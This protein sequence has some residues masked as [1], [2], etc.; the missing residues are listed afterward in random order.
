MATTA[1][2]EA[3]TSRLGSPRARRVVS[4]S[5]AAGTAVITVSTL[6]LGFVAVRNVTNQAEGDILVLMAAIVG[7]AS[8]G[9]VGAILAAR[10]PTSPLGFLFQIGAFSMALAVGGSVYGARA[11]ADLPGLR[12]VPY[13]GW[14][15]QI[16]FTPAFG[17]TFSVF[18]LFPD[19]LPPSRRWRPVSWL[20]W[21]GAVLAAVGTTFGLR[22]F[23]FDPGV[24][25]NPF[26][27][28]PVALFEAINAVGGG[29][30]FLA[31]ILAVV[32]VVVRFRRSRGEERQQ[33]RWITWSAALILGCVVA[34]VV[35]GTAFS[36]H[37]GAFELAFLA[38]IT[39]VLVGLPVATAIAVLR[40]RLYELDL[41]VQKTAIYSIVAIA[42]TA[43]YMGL[44]GVAALTGLGTVPAAVVSV[45][46][47]NAARSRARRL[48]DRIVY[49]RRATPFEVLSEFS[50][51]V[52]ETYS[53]DDVLPRMTQLLAAGTGAREARTWIRQGPTLRSA[54]VSPPDADATPDVELADEALPPF[55]EGVHAFAVTHQG[56]LLGAIT[57]T[58]AANDP[59]DATKERLAQ[60]V[61]SQAG[62]A[63]RNVRLVEDLRASR[64]RIVAAQDERAKTLERNIHDGAQQQLVA[65]TVRLR[66]AE[67]MAER[68]PSSV[69]AV[70]RD[71]QEQ[72]STAL[73]DLRDLARGIYPPLLADKG[74]EAALKSQARKAAVPVDLE[75]GDVGRHPQEV[76][77]T[78]YF[79]VLEALNNVAKYAQ[80]RAAT[81]SLSRTDGLLTFEVRDDGVGFDATA[82]SYG[83]GLQGMADRLDAVGGSLTVHS[84]PGHGAVVHGEIPVRETSEEP[85]VAIDG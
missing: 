4:R 48:A 37:P 72:A 16:A 79:C 56:E 45:L 49:G 8:M 59:M 61:A 17:A 3:R 33:L 64:R 62:L 35:S 75:T 80:A 63:L 66:L 70:L 85:T 50:E 55:G 26:L 10:A 82:N 69:S 28:Q 11:T 27:L 77:S 44:L 31:G 36:D 38:L 71:L 68:D 6:A 42:L 40:Y 7:I 2:S 83:T 15:S 67:Q 22:R 9:V 20:L 18:L 14:L 23:E 53:I 78:V 19:G 51:R 41:V 21:A 30:M 24:A 54:A 47:V 57:L 34:L 84:A 65:L 46:T 52:G 13:A 76:E 25:A 32:S 81:I 60:G 58:L 73:D 43:L 5:L 1:G 12:G 39:S 29:M 74:L